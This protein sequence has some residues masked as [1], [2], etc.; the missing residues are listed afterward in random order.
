L[1]YPCVERVKDGSNANDFY[2]HSSHVTCCR[3]GYD[4]KYIFT[5]GGE[6]Q[7]VMQWK[8]LKR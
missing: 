8:V 6:D 4:D 3:F 1:R 7:C 5:T 2:G